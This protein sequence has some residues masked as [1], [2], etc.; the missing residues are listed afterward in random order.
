MKNTLK[1]VLAPIAGLALVLGIAVGGYKLYWF[2]ERDTT[3][4]Q[5]HIYQDSYGRQNSLVTAILADIRDA[6]DPN[7]PANQRTGIVNVICDS[8]DQ[9]I[10]TTS[11][12]H[13][14]SLSLPRS[15]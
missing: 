6:E 11:V 3:N 15:S 5:A 13:K 2:I 14:D 4:K 10:R 12:R 1:S 9:L 8:Y 7:I